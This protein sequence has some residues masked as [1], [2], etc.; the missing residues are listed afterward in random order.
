L[1]ECLIPVDQIF[2]DCPKGVVEEAHIVAVANG[3]RLQRD[4]LR[5][6]QE[7]AGTDK[8]ML[9]RIYDAAG[10]FYGLYEKT[11]EP[12]FLKPRQMFI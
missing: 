6:M 11:P 10:R 9:F 3:N 7:D 1:E 5:T 2:E 12:G 4:W 8:E